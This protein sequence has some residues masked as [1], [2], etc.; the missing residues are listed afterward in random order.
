MLIIIIILLAA[1][2]VIT[3]NFVKL[4]S[5]IVDAFHSMM[6]RKPEGLQVQ[7]FENSN[8]HTIRI[9][10]NG[11]SKFTKIVPQTDLII[12]FFLNQAMLNRLDLI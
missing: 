12:Y 7:N 11:C 6:N 9:R 8:K 4:V 5:F 3:N 10:H 1:I 2:A